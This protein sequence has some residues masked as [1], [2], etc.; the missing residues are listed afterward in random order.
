MLPV[1]DLAVYGHFVGANLDISYHRV[2]VSWF[3]PW[4]TTDH[5]GPVVVYHEP[6]SIPSTR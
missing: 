2:M 3:S 6:E 1:P 5:L 4:Q